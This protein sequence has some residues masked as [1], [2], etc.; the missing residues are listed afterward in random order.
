MAVISNPPPS[1]CR[2]RRRSRE[3]FPLFLAGACLVTAVTGFPA[4]DFIYVVQ[5]GDN[6]WNL[7]HRYLK[8]MSYWPRIQDY[9]RI[10]DPTSI[11]PGTKWLVPPRWMR[12]RMVSLAG[13][14]DGLRD[15]R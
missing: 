13:K 5:P 11:R 6:P 10:T 7:T 1:S 3:Q 9:N 14:A 12:G 4:E 8:S 2:R 15:G